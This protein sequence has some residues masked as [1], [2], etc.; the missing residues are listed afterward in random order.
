MTNPPFSSIKVTREYKSTC[1]LV[2]KNGEKQTDAIL[3][4]LLVYSGLVHAALCMAI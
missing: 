3:N 1:S 4:L 2:T